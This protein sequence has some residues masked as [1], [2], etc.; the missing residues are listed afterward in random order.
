MKL[1]VNWWIVHRKLFGNAKNQELV[2]ALT[3]LY[4][5]A[6]GVEPDRVKEATRLRA[7]GML[8]SDLWVNEGKPADS[9][10]L[11][12]EEAALYQSYKALKG[13]IA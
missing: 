9:P 3:D 12:Q 5:E 4:A 11:A 6:Y 2:D 7:M 10:L 13:A 8:Y 1:E